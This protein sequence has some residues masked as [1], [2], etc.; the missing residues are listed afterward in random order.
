MADRQPGRWRCLRT[1]H[2]RPAERYPGTADRSDLNRDHHE[3]V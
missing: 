1:P 3:A 2:E